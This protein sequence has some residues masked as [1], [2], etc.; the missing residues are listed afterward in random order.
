[1]IALEGFD[2]T[3]SGLWDYGTE[4]IECLEL[5]PTNVY[6]RDVHICSVVAWCIIVASDAHCARIIKHT[7][8]SLWAINWLHCQAHRLRIYR[9]GSNLIII[10][11]MMLSLH[12]D[13]KSY[14]IQ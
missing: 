8:Q 11:I 1:M 10:K 3:F 14:K 9:L 7:A 5:L 12:Q 13:S 2:V 6:M 4:L